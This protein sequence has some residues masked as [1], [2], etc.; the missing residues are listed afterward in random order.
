MA[1]K[2]NG[3]R[4]IDEV[5]SNDD[6]AIAALKYI[7]SFI[8]VE[9]G[10]KKMLST[11]QTLLPGVVTHVRTLRQMWTYRTEQ[12]DP[13]LDW[14]MIT[15]TDYVTLV[16]TILSMYCG[17]ISASVPPPL[18]KPRSPTSTVSNFQSNLL[19]EF[20]K[21]IKRNLT[22]FPTL[23]GFKD[24][25]SFIRLFRIETKA[26]GLS[27][28]LDSTYC[29]RTDEEKSLFV[30]QNDFM[31]S[32]FDKKLKT[33]K[34]KEAIRQHCK[35]KYVAQKIFADI[36]AHAEQGT[37]A[38]ID[39]QRIIKYLTTVQ[40]GSP[41][42]RST[43]GA[44]AFVHHYKDKLLTYKES[45]GGSPFMPDIKIVM[46]QN[47]VATLP[48]LAAIQHMDKLLRAHTGDSLD[49][50]K[51]FDLLVL[52]AIRNDKSPAGSTG[53]VKGRS[54]YTHDM[55]PDADDNKPLTSIDSSIDLLHVFQMDSMP[56][57]HGC[58]P[59]GRHPPSTRLPLSLVRPTSQQSQRGHSCH[60]QILGYS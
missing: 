39:S 42:F 41:T 38:K 34:A 33:D 45:K 19:K 5:F 8:K 29:P 55:Y 57:L 40:W 3:L 26:Q 9:D 52:T 24:W 50:N 13:I 18:S 31:L 25:D 14:R 49:F 58:N 11:P 15:Q 4:S 12:F 54:V 59:R 7:D 37:A 53:N 27:N 43:S 22:Q 10:S 23:N 21:G 46:F 6:T 48:E 32:V 30:C 17:M 28:I 16:Y 60:H 20:K 56:S 36:K 1:I 47:A 35:S 51:Y 44:E 2:Q